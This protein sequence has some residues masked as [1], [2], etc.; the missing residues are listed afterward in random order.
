MSQKETNKTLKNTSCNQNSKSLEDPSFINK[1]VS[2]D[3]YDYFAEIV[4]LKHKASSN[5]MSTAKESNKKHGNR[6]K[7]DSD[8]DLD[9]FIEE[10]LLSDAFSSNEEDNDVFIKLKLKEEERVSLLAMLF[11]IFF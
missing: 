7:N 3:A 9:D 4:S 5:E 1:Q 8:Y 10:S 11:I 6:N 2:P